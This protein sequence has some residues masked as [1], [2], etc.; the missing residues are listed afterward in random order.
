[1][2]LRGAGAS[3][4]VRVSVGDRSGRRAKFETTPR[5]RRDESEERDEYRAFNTVVGEVIRRARQGHG[6]TQVMLAERAGLSANYVARLERGELGPSLFV[7]H[8]IALAL[9][10]G[11]DAL[12]TPT[13][14]PGGARRPGKQRALTG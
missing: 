10:I 7:A 11:I 3:A 14:A 6:W 9:G 1:M 2:A 13:G 12:V 5:E 4:K 8:R